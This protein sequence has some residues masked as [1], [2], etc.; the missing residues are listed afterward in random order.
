MVLKLNDS[1][2][3]YKLPNTHPYTKP[4]T[5]YQNIKISITIL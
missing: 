5:N 2:A 4:N 1:E 3:I